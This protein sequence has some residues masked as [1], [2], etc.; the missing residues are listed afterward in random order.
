M[1]KTRF[2]MSMLK[3]GSNN[4]ALMEAITSHNQ[5]TVHLCLDDLISYA[6]VEKAKYP[7]TQTGFYIQRDKI[8]NSLILI[9]EDAG[10]TWTMII[11]EKEI[12]EP[13]TVGVGLEQ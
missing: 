4:C 13:E 7:N 11:E 9:S 5:G 8:N 12:F 1:K 3:K 6:K 2:N 10:Q